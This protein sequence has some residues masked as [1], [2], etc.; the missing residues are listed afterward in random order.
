MNH[1][2]LKPCSASMTCITSFRGLFSPMYRRS[3]MGL[4]VVHGSWGTCE[5]FPSGR[6]WI[7]CLGASSTAWPGT[8]VP[9]KAASD[10]ITARA[11]VAGAQL[12]CPTS[13]LPGLTCRWDLSAQPWAT[14]KQAANYDPDLVWHGMRHRIMGEWVAVMEPQSLVT[15]DDVCWLLLLRMKGEFRHVNR[16]SIFVMLALSKAAGQDWANV[17]IGSGKSVIIIIHTRLGGLVFYLD[18]C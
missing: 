12:G 1:V 3:M 15:Q 8:A 16:Q 11:D 17:Q 13:T 5:L 18:L 4:Y 6:R 14:R 10:A 7:S 9:A 2:D